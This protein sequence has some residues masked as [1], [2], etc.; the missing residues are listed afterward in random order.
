[1]I[2]VPDLFNHPLSLRAL[3]LLS[4]GK[5]FMRYRNPY[6][7]QAWAHRLEFYQR[8]WRDAAEQLG[9]T[10]RDLGGGII[11]IE[12]DGRRTRVSDNYSSID[13]AMTL[14]VLSDKGVTYQILQDHGLPVPPHRQFS[15]KRMPEAIEFLTDAQ[16]DEQSL[17]CVVKPMRGTGGGRGITTG[18]QSNSQLARA[19]AAAA[20]YC[21]DL[22]IERQ[23][24]GE[25]HRLLYLDGKLIDAIVR[26][27]PV[28]VGDGRSTVKEL[29]KQA[30]HERLRRK[31]GKS[32][33]LLT[34]DLDMK[35][36]LARAGLSLQSVPQA[37]QQVTLKT[38]VNENCGEDNLTATE[39]LCPR[40]VEEG[41]EAVAA[42]SVRLGG[43]DVITT[44]PSVSLADSGGAILE[45][46]AP[47]NF[48]YH[49][50]K[51]DGV[52][53]VALHVL[54]RLLVESIAEP[55]VTPQEMLPAVNFPAR[56]F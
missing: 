55:G 28:V 47:P 13:D 10:H 42:L 38:V 7:V 11:E 41:A 4:L 15:L 46:N 30:N 22:L 19:A 54:R 45:V 34:I 29:V 39:Q 49:Y 2:L 5:G 27:S 36:T 1:M 48:Y 37:G 53:P 51:K 56:S 3:Y 25:N 24:A 43:V 21:D 31:T 8:S 35:R 40:L 9:A 6:R 17:G 20:I 18:I 50:H 23:I 32:Q 52:F 14:K 44:D 16:Q 33:V 12:L 26:Q